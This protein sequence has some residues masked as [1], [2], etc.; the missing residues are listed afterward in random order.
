MCVELPRANTPV[1]NKHHVKMRIN[2][3]TGQS[4]KHNP[5]NNNGQESTYMALQPQLPSM[6]VLGIERRDVTP[7]RGRQ[8]GVGKPRRA[9]YVKLPVIQSVCEAPGGLTSTK[10]L[11]IMR[12]LLLLPSQLHP[13]GVKLCHINCVHPKIR[14]HGIGVPLKEDVSL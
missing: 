1:A 12:R 13:T 4:H 11:M 3:F 7:H 9:R 14:T 6:L 10:V 5:K 8:I 2:D